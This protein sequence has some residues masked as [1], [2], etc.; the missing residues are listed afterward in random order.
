MRSDRSV[1]LVGLGATTKSAFEALTER[2]TVIGLVRPGNDE[3][4]QLA[5]AAGIRVVS[6][7]SMASV[8]QVIDELQPDAVVVSSYNRVLPS[9][10][11]LARPFIN[12]HYAPLPRYRGR[13]TVNWAVLNG[14]MDTAISIHCLT[15]QLDAGGILAQQSIP[16]G[17]RDTVS[18]LYRR[19]NELQRKLLADA[20]ERRLDG[21]LGMA[22]DE[23]AATYCCGRLPS[24]G[25]VEWAQSA[26]AIDRLIRSLGGDFPAAFT[27]LGTRHIEILRAEP[28]LGGRHYVGAIPGRVVGV[29]RGLGT[30]EVLAGDGTIRLDT[31]RLPGGTA[32]P[33]ADVITSTRMSL[34]IRVADLSLLLASSQPGVPRRDAGATTS[35]PVIP[36]APASVQPFHDQV[37]QCS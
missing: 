19:L 8:S 20:V 28:V 22:Q 11:L 16:I 31:V 33:A 10:L 4:V 24:D 9:S 12:V 2:F 25:M 17:P 13:A 37:R 27:H 35:A 5:D 18:D 30:V 14:E 36:T 23:S 26:A 32:Q 1:L 21:D 34:G 15:E 7:T 3:V 6:D 29:D